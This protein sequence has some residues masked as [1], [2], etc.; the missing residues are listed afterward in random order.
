MT[1]YR[2]KI[3]WGLVT[4]LLIVL[5]G[6]LL[7]AIFDGVWQMLLIIVP[8]II[9]IAHMYINTYY[10]VKDNMLIVKCGFTKKIF[11]INTF[12]KIAET[13]NAASAPALSQDRL[14][15]FYN[16]Y[17]SI[18]ISPKNKAGFITHIQKINP[19]IEYLA[20]AKK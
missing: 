12:R 3:S 11:D 14:E 18:V 16:G 17:E 1:V 15:L 8:V 9:F 5:G 19:A 10:I 7:P 13:N 6:C 20:E 4:F 2:S